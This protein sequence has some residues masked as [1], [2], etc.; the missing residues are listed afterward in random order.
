MIYTYTAGQNNGRITQSTDR[1]SGEVVNY[2]YDSLNR[3]ASAQATN[4]S[5]GN[6]YSYDG[7]GNLTAKTVT[8]GSAPN[9]A[10]SYN[11]ATNQQNGLNYDAN[12]NVAMPNGSAP[13]DVE[14]RLLYSADG[15]Y[16]FGYDPQGKRVL[17]QTASGTYPGPLTYSSEFSFYGITGQLL[18]TFVIWSTTDST[19]SIYPYQAMPA[20]LKNV[21]FG[22]RLIL[23]SGMAVVTDRLGSVRTGASYY[24]WGEDRGSAANQQIK[25]GTYFRDLP[26]EDYADQRYY[27]S[28]AGRFYTPDSTTGNLVN[29]SSWNK[30]AY[31]NGDP[32]N[33]NDSHGR[34]ACIVGV[35]ENAEVT[36]CEDV[37]VNVPGSNPN[38]GCATVTSPDDPTWQQCFGLPSSTQGTGT[39]KQIKVS[40]YQTTSP[41]ATGVQN[42]LRWI[43]SELP[44]DAT[45]DSWLHNNSFVIDLV[46][47]NNP[48]V[49]FQTGVGDFSDP[50]V[51]AVFGNTGTNLG[52]NAGIT[53][54]ANGAYFSSSVTVGVGVTGITGG[55]AAAQV[56]ILLH[57]LAHATGA[58]GFL[59]NDS[60]PTRQAA[61]NALV[62]QN[63]QKSIDF[64]GKP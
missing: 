17:R 7:F 40:N 28:N 38:L 12:G 15:A 35:G 30:Y 46:L 42:A 33:F 20:A 53:V 61:N 3:L 55:T 4:G 5:W 21:Y 16:A 9:F 63:C 6:A 43:Q 47:G 54:N 31:T 26:G 23:E 44:N 18:A 22:G 48:D 2:T 32:V 57:E 41:K 60:D 29:P 36:E 58:A 34:Y 1:A 13:Y 49:K 62:L 45:C 25:F 56:F 19:Q 64:F 50:T 37:S 39:S 14:N 8:A 24:P 11:P 52:L 59:D 10:A 51:N 27:N